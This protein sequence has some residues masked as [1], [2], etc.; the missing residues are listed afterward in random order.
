MPLRGAVGR[1]A[2]V[3]VRVLRDHLALV[4][5]RSLAK[6][7]GGSP[8]LSIREESWVADPQQEHTAILGRARAGDERAEDELIA[9]VYD[10]LRRVAGRLMRRE[11]ADHTLSPTAV[12]HEAVIRLLGDAVFDKA[13]DRSYLFAS[14]AR[15]MREVLIDHARRR[16]ADRR[17]GGRR[18]VPLDVVVDYFEEQGLDVVAV[19]EALDRLAELERAPGPGHDPAVLRRADRRRG[20]RG[21]GGLGGH[22]RAGL[23]ARAGL[24]RRPARR[25]GRMTP[26][27]WRRI[28]DLFDAALRLDPAER[29]AWLRDACG[30]DDD[31]RAEVGRLLAQDERADRDGFLTPPEATGR[32][33]DRTGSWPPRGASRPPRRARADRP[34]SGTRRSTTPAASRPGRRSPRARGRTRSPS[35]ESVVRARLRELPMIYILILAMAIFWRRVVL[36]DD[37]PTLYHLDVIVIVALVGVIALLSSRWP[38]SLAWLKALELGM[39]GMLAGRVAIVQYRLMLV[40]SLR[41]DPMMAQLT[42]K[43]IVLLTVDPDPHLRAL[44]PEELAPRRARGGAA[45]AAALRDLA[46]PLPAAPRGDGLARARVEEERDPAAPAVQLRCDDP[47]HPGRRLAFGARTISRLRRQVAEAR[48]LGQ[49]RLRRRIGAGGMGEVYLAEHQLL[50]RPCAVKL[51]RPDDV[52]DPKA[53]ERFERE[54]RLTATL[55]HPNTVEIYDYGRTEDGTY[56]YV[57]EYLP[58]L[59]LAELV[60]R[61]GPLPPG[62]RS[63]CCGRSAWRCARRTR[64]A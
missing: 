61:H 26:E 29:E 14:A 51:I 43:N 54:V 15:A 10:E 50:K 20:R 47:A 11:R 2:A 49:Y 25:E 37:D 40:F 38:I 64:R 45:R 6:N 36:G 9:L 60:E 34:P 4:P 39:I 3:S 42:M 1:F 17:G 5:P 48:Q 18:R 24:A 63:T 52:A 19:H 62:G 32:P 31:L 23:A 46:G 53:L 22:G 30:G 41:D 35:P 16:A 27:R 55:S 56:Y 13:A 57:M 8:H 7:P 58:G 21:A 12:V 28:D 33:P 59:S 44:R